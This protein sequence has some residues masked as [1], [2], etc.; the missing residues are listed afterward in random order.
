MDIPSGVIIMWPSTAGS[1]PA[2]WARE[3]TLDGRFIVG[4]ADS[5]NPN[6][7]GGANTH[8]HSQPA[9]S[10]NGGS[11]THTIPTYKRATSSNGPYQLRWQ[12]WDNAVNGW[13]N[14]GYG[15]DPGGN[16]HTHGSG[17]SG[18]GTNNLSSAG[19]SWV[20]G[21]NLPSYYETIFIKSDGSSS[22]FP[23][24][25]STFWSTASLP[26]GWSLD[27]NVGDR[28]LRGASGSNSG[29]TCGGSHSHNTSSHSHPLSHSHPGF[30]G[31]NAAPPVQ[32]DPNG[33]LGTGKIEGGYC[34]T[35]QY[36]E[37]MHNHG[38]TP[39]LSGGGSS[40]GGGGAGSGSATP[41]PKYKKQ[42]AIKNGSGSS[43]Y[44]SDGG[45]ICLWLGTLANI[46]TDW[47]LCD[48][49]NGTPDMRNY[50]ATGTSSTGNVGASA[51][52]N[53]SHNHSTSSH[54]HG[55]SHNHGNYGNSYA[56][57]PLE[58]GCHGPVTNI[59][60]AGSSGQGT[61][62]PQA[63]VCAAATSSGDA[64]HIGGATGSGGAGSGGGTQTIGSY[65]ET[66]AWRSVAF[67]FG[68]EDAAGGNV[69][70]FGSSF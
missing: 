54:N 23:N 24:G 15:P 20:A 55:G 44:P 22:D 31:T 2:G 45:A 48:G 37:A 4:T 62:P 17:A 40:G 21:S 34:D 64:G 50:F 9:H 5:T 3:T 58:W 26:E 32:P 1:I 42:I 8:I 38:T 52:A 10:H 61:S 59:G 11:H 30:S 27:S 14:L 29:A 47:Y 33:N 41:V 13:S 66:P 70:M 51:N 39:S 12:Q 67:I 69:G 18:A 63:N 19:Q 28:F 57:N 7:T 65:D 16:E 43:D 46:P 49:S 36:Y 68:P 35:G 56:Y 25:S 6:N 60:C 53:T